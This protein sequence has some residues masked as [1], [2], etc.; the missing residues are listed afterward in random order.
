MSDFAEVVV[1]VE[2]QTEQKFVKHLLAPYMAT[3]GIYL[4]PVILNKPGQKGGDVKFS[5]AR[6]D[7]ERHL[8]QRQDTW[9]TLMVDYYGIKSDWPGY[10]ESKQ[11]PD[12]VKK[13]EVMNKATATEVEQL[14]PVQNRM[15]RF[16]PYVSMHEIESLFFS[17][18]SCL[19]KHSGIN[20]R[21]IDKILASCKE[22]E[23][24]ND[25]PDTAPS[26]RII[27]LASSYKKTITGIAIAEETGIPA[28]REACPLFNAW[29]CQLESLTERSS[30]TLNA[31]IRHR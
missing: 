10:A 23:G 28:I 14:F 2:G 31:L 8:K 22:P 12:H 4:V 11:Q 17:N 26:K 5:R 24:I 1:L 7:I 25:H 27:K 9:V 15:E 18:P 3:K 6:N 20:Q 29:L 30:A 13:A 16:I 21:E 19:A